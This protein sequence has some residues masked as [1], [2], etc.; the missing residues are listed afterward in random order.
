MAKDFYKY[1]I[2][3]FCNHKCGNDLCT[4]AEKT[5]LKWIDENGT[6]QKIDKLTSELTAEDQLI[7]DEYNNQ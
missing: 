3:K 1:K 2:F 4:C 7:I 5:L 6:H